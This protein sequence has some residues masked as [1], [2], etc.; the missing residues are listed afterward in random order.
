MRIAPPTP[1]SIAVDDAHTVSAL[2]TV[3]EGARA[4]Y[5]FAHGAGAGMT[6]PAMAASAQALAA[7]GMASLR[8]Q[9]PYME[10]GAGRPDLPALCHATIR[11]AVAEAGRRSPGLPLLAG[12]RSFGGRMTSQAQ[13]LT[14]LPHVL[15]LV[16]Y[17]FPLHPSGHP[18]DERARHLSQ[19]SIPM[20]FLQGDRDAL[21][22]ID[23]LEPVVRRLAPRAT[24]RLIAGA[25]HAFE[26]PARSARSAVEVQAELA[27]RVRDWLQS[28]IEVA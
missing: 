12:G 1:L 15:G 13:A 7:I 2:L 17:A 18:G 21:A 25:D 27:L 26:L 8:F 6:H 22:Q 10:R 19:V 3:P 23:C 16:F 28:L 14:P 11:A 4:C 20:L 9:F 24:L 5:V